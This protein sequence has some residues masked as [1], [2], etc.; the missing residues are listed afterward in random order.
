[1]AALIYYVTY[2][3]PRDICNDIWIHANPLLEEQKMRQDSEGVP[4]P[5]KAEFV[6]Q[7]ARAGI[8]YHFDDA[9]WAAKAGGR[10]LDR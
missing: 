5:M 7:C 6:A 4:D 8:S 1:M 3:V 2:Q 10:F 9:Y